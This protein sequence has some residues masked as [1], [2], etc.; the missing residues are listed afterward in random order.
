M[1]EAAPNDGNDAYGSADCC[2]MKSQSFSGSL[3]PKASELNAQEAHESAKGDGVGQRLGSPK[4]FKAEVGSVNCY[5]VF[6]HQ[7]RTSA[8]VQYSEALAAQPAHQPSAAET[9]NQH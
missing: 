6:S 5:T 3:E 1:R 4:A 9:M 7:N 8:A 2:A